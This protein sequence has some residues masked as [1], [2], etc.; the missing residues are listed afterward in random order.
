[1]KERLHDRRYSNICDSETQESAYM[2]R[3]GGG[4]RRE[5]GQKKLLQRR[6]HG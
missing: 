6:R 3:A 5:K 1:M 4:T 2:S